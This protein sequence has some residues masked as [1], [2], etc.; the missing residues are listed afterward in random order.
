MSQTQEEVDAAAKA[1]YIAWMGDERWN[2]EQNRLC[3]PLAFFWASIAANAV[4]AAAQSRA[5]ADDKPVTV[6]DV[7]NRMD[8]A[9][10][11]CRAPAEREIVERCAMVAEECPPFVKFGDGNFRNTN[12]KDAA[13]A[14]RALAAPASPLHDDGWRDDMENAPKDGRLIETKYISDDPKMVRWHSSGDDGAGWYLDGY[15]AQRLTYNPARLTY[16]PTHWRPLPPPPRDQ[17]GEKP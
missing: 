13:A 12:P 9:V 7:L 1:I 11:A 6:M 15:D 2:A 4:L 14:I 10:Q 5:P 3:R 17:D 8:D 16:E